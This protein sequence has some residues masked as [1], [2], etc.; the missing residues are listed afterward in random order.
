MYLYTAYLF[1]DFAGYSLMAVG[2]S[3][4]LGIDRTVEMKNKLADPRIKERVK[5]RET[6]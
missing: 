2:A 6:E 4:I 5:T 1:F 3:N